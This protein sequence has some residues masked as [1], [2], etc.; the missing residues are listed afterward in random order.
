MALLWSSFVSS[1]AVIILVK[2]CNL[3]AGRSIIFYYYFSL[4]TENA[5][6]TLVTPVWSTGPSLFEKAPRENIKIPKGGL[7]F[8]STSC[9]AMNNLPQATTRGCFLG[10]AGNVLCS[11][12]FVHK[13]GSGGFKACCFKP[14]L[15]LAEDRPFYRNE[16]YCSLIIPRCVGCIHFLFQASFLYFHLASN[17]PPWVTLTTLIYCDVFVE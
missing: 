4:L 10:V 2:T 9:I 1:T 8:I 3:Q 5:Q 11:T 12:Q 16:I 6:N 13:S 15:S 7:C 14:G 17:I